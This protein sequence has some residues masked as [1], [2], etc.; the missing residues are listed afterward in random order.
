M[1]IYNRYDIDTHF[2]VLC[3]NRIISENL[4]NDMKESDHK[5]SLNKI[6][7]NYSMM[8]H[9]YFLK[10]KFLIKYKFVITLLI[11]VLIM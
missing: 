5:L 10:L 6:F 7:N 9:T 4:A 8:S 11:S 3:N 1:S 2:N